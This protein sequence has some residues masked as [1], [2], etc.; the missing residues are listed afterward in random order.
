M[1]IYLK[2][3][4]TVIF[5][6]LIKNVY[7]YEIRDPIFENYFNQINEELR[8]K[9]VNA[10]L[11]K[12]NF[13]NAFVLNDNIYITTEL[14]NIIKEEDTMKAI[15]LH[16]YNISLKITCMPQSSHPTIHC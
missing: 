15:F 10:Y 16:E 1:K 7:S 11:V 5:L 8:L 4:F 3:T 6:F 12:N 2:L 14:L 9:K 13:P